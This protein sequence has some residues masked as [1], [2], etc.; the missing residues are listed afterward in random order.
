M[1]GLRSAIVAGFVIAVAG[2]PGPLHGE[3]PVQAEKSAESSE[4]AIPAQPPAEAAPPAIAPG[5]TISKSNWMQYRQFFTEGEIGLWE[6]RWFWEMPDDV[7]INVGTTKM[8]ALPQPYVE[9]TEKYGE[10]TQLIRLPDGRWRLKN[11]IAGMPFPIP[12]EPNLGLKILSNMNYR[13][14]PHLVAGFNDSGTM[15]RICGIDRFGNSSRFLVDYDFRQMAYNWEPGVP[16]VEPNSGQA[17]LGEW[18]QAEEPEQLRYSV[19]LVLLWQDNLR[20]EGHYAFI[21]AWRR[22]MVLSDTSHCEPLLSDND[23]AFN[24][25][26]WRRHPRPREFEPDDR[27]GGWFQPVAGAVPSAISNNYNFGGTPT[28]S[29]QQLSIMH[30]AWNGGIGEYDATFVKRQ[31]LLALTQLGPEYGKFPENYDMPLGW[32]KP[33]WGN[34]E[35][36]N[37]W[38]IDVHPIPLIG[39]CQRKRVIYVDTSL[40]APLAE[41]LYDE[42]MDLSKVMVLSSQPQ[43]VAGYGMQTW[44]GGGIL[45]LWD[46]VSGHAYMSLTADE[47]GRTWS[48]DSA[49]KP[50]Y[51][52]IS[53]FQS[54][55]GLME[56]M[57]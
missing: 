20:P 52:S 17:W 57:R 50:Q 55:G 47:R 48:I 15:G 10:Q 46:V 51:N 54:P 2:L 42:K 11:Y 56:L 28:T 34:W 49:V 18:V 31:Q 12:R 40:S 44:A 3:Q 7:Q 41:D 27:I 33:S 19:D 22:T 26:K 5:T 45:Q 13:I 8:Y 43:A 14:A 25:S 23:P 1:R 4:S 29:P 37:V 39:R 32:A 35:L 6:G 30:G 36:R 38:V 9:L 16:R 21:P 24:D 53:A